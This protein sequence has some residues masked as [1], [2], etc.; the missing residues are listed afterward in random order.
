ML[1]YLSRVLYIISDSKIKL[2]LLLLGFAFSSLIETIGISLLAPFMAL[3][4]DPRQSNLPQYLQEIKAQ[5]SINSNSQLITIIGFFII[6]FFCLKSLI[7]FSLKFYTFHFSSHYKSKISLKL[8][9]SY[10]AVPYEFHLNRNTSSLIKN[11]VIETNNLH[12]TCLLPLLNILSN[13]II[14]FFL[15]SLLAF[16]DLNS[17]VMILIVLLPLLLSFHLL[18]NKFAKWGKTI[19][20]SQQKMITTINHAMGG[21]KETKVIG[22]EP[23]FE[24]EMAGHVNQ[25]ARS[26]TLFQS[27]QALPRTLIETVLIVFVVLLVIN[28]QSSSAQ[29]MQETMAVISVFAVAGM[30][31]IPS[32][33]IFLKSAAQLRNGSYAVSMLYRDLKDIDGQTKI[34]SSKK[35]LDNKSLDLKEFPLKH[36]DSMVFNRNLKLK[37]VTYSYSQ[38]TSAALEDISL[39][40]NKGESI[41][42]I[43]KSGA[44]KTTLVDIILGLLN[45]QTGDILVDEVSIYKN[46]RSWQNLVGYIPQSIFLIDDTIE[47]NIAFGV[48]EA[49]IDQIKLQEVIQATQL[50]DFLETLPKG[51]H[52]EV[53]ERGARLSGGQRQRIGIARALYHEKEIL[54]LDEATSALDTETE[55]LIN[56]SIQALAGK[57]TLIIIAHRLSTIEDCDRVYLLEKG[58]VIRS[59]SYEEI[60]LQTC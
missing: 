49:E 9:K 12:Q 21:L 7:S 16:T 38:N 57:K 40:I 44:G 47:K 54:V 19:S 18:R 35:L 59:G 20:Q 50:F 56:K 25:Y 52:T 27:F 23:Y 1:G 6:I 53:G 13:T 33:S 15:L 14:I 28:A 4:S 8:L 46:I 3:A 32:L 51:V 34:S 41:A 36:S 26:I 22:C 42:F 39:E 17:L 29:S 10:L 55:S 24:E 2:I 31:L 5:L 48:C 60:V 11:I 37:Q 30:R 45:P 58:R 43:G